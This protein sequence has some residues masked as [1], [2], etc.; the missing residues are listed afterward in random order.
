MSTQVPLI[1]IFEWDVSEPSNPVGTRHIPGGHPAFK[2][3]VASGCQTF[4]P[5]NPS[6]T[7]GTLIFEDV[8]FNLVDNTPS[9]IESKVSALTFNILGSGTAASDLKL[10]LVDDSVFQ[11]S[12]DVGLDAG[13]VQIVGSGNSWQYQ[14]ILPSGA[15]TRLST[16]IPTFPNVFREDG[17]AGLV[18]EDDLNSSEFVYMNVVIPLGNPLGDFG[19]CGSGLLRFGLIFNFWCNDF[20]LDIG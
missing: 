4:D 10:Y 15:G 16:T 17:T 1:R 6:T 9:H 11:A 2:R 3:M 8:I 13:F 14:G 20:I 5:N 19:V 7:S 18:G 12:R